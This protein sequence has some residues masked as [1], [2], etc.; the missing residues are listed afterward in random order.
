[1]LFGETVA[2]YYDN[3]TKHIDALCSQNAEFW[4]VTAG[5]T[6]NNHRA[7]K[8][9]KYLCCYAVRVVGASFNNAEPPRGNFENSHR[10]SLRV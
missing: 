5:G 1:M 3:H 9:Y 6:Y 4:Y 7:L 8:G 10:R 2:V